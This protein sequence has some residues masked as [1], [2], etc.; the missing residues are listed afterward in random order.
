METKLY[1]PQLIT[2]DGNMDEE[3]WQ[4]VEEHTGFKATI[5]QGGKPAFRETFFKILP[6]ADRIFVGIKCFEPD[7]DLALEGAVHNHIWNND[8]VE[9]FL[10]PSGISFDFYQFAITLTGASATIFYSEG[11]TIRPD[12]YAPDWQYAIHTDKDFWSVEIALPL[13][14]FYMT[15]DMSWSNQWLINVCRTHKN[16]RNGGTKSFWSWGQVRMD[17]KETMGLRPMD[18][19]PMRP[20]RDALRIV[21]ATVDVAGETKEGFC[22]TMT[23]KVVAP[24][25]NTFTFEAD[26][27][28]SVTVELSAGTN[29][30][31]VPCCFAQKNRRYQIAMQLTRL[32]DGEVFKRQ[33]PV[34]VEYEPIKL[35]MVLPEFRGNFYPGQDVS[36]V[37]G[38]LISAKPATVKLEG[39]GFE[40]QVVT[41]DEEGNF[42]FDT[43]GFQVGEGLLTVT[44]EDQVLTKKI[45]RLAPSDHTMA[46]ISGGNLIVD[47]KAV[48]RRNMYATYYAGGEAFRQRYD[49]DNLHVTKQVVAQIGQMQPDGILGNKGM[50][51]EETKKD[52]KPSEEVF[53]EIDRIMEH[54]KDRDFVYYYLSDEPEMRGVSPRYLKYLYDYI[55]EKDPHHVI[56]MGS[57]TPNRLVECADWI[58]MHP[59]INVEV[60][61]GVRYCTRDINTLG[62]FVDA[63]VR[64]NRSDKCFGF[65]PTCFAGKS[66]NAFADYPN[67][68]EM[69]CHTWAAMI[70]GGK[71]LWPY[72]YHDMNDRAALYEGI[73][74]LFSSFEALEDFILFGKRSDLLKTQDVHGVLYELEDKKLFVLVNMTRDPQNAAIAGISGLYAF[75]RGGKITGNDFA[76]KPLEVVIGTSEAMDTG[77][78]TFAETAALVEKME[79]ARTHRG[80]LLFERHREIDVTS[81]KGARKHKLFDGILDNYGWE[82]STNDEKF[83]ELNLTR[84]KPSFRKVSVYGCNIENAELKIRN[85]DALSVPAIKEVQM[86]EHGKTFLLESAICPDGIRFEFDAD[87][88]ELYEIEVF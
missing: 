47:G 59:Y 32:E 54:N 8:S 38:R 67:F 12:P 4:S 16:Y 53:R 61:D 14:A 15:S 11:G 49:A 70:H 62:E 18:G 22:G 57:T 9:L 71:T 24:E 5:A 88:V 26:N 39:P 68:E 2:L 37:V 27:A 52:A 43:V 35:K 10:A 46:W 77:L 23:V 55:T 79:Y 13:K 48:L 82:D 80:S 69:V 65:L 60:Q 3:V 42:V 66:K 34:M 30:F 25:V 58:E 36:K 72:A 20:L 33:Y 63:G 87:K 41:P 76:L 19:F 31:T 75:R 44:A 6:C 7:M 28:E 83:L 85:G 21:S 40:T 50:S 84:I 1:D 29:E 51:R 78:P 73:R 17:Y 64:L 56:L 74:Y 45:R 86:E 81:S